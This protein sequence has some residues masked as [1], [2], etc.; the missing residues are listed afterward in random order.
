M[1]L[2]ASAIAER[3]EENF[4]SKAYGI[5]LEAQGFGPF[6]ASGLGTARPGGWRPSLKQSGSSPEAIGKGAQFY[7]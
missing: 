7:C 3:A 2:M 4:P 5:Y 6:V 1:F